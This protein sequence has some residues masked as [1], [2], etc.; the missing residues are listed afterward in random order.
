MK[1][2]P[3]VVSVLNQ[4]GGVA[5]TTTT[6]NLGSCLASRGHRTL[7]IDMDP[8]ANLTLGLGVK[9]GPG[10]VGLHDVLERKAGVRLDHIVETIEGLPLAVAPA[11]FDLGR[12]EAMLTPM[13]ASCYRLKQAL[14]TVSDYELILID[15]PPSL[16]RLTEMAIVAST[17]LLIPTEP[18]LY[19]FAGMDTLNRMISDLREDLDLG[20]ELLGVLLTMDE[21]RT[22]LHR[23]IGEEVRQ[24]FGEHVFETSIRRTVRISES[25]L[26]GKAAILLDPSSTASQDYRALTD[27]VLARLAASPASR[28]EPEVVKPMDPRYPLITTP[29]DVMLESDHFGAAAIVL[30]SSPEPAGATTAALTIPAGPD[31]LP[32]R[33]DSEILFEALSENLTG[34]DGHSHAVVNEIPSRRGGIGSFLQ[35]FTRKL[36]RRR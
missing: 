23:T 21:K 29:P 27:E 31:P 33:S 28:P 6:A 9:V 17:H 26:E 15:C 19:S 5:K 8:Q 10:R 18:K 32:N 11:S 14:E 12:A 20:V 7:L 4:K 24:R 34:A 22:K 35:D 36:S 2:S 30:E 25:E 3:R 13:A 1:P 16:G